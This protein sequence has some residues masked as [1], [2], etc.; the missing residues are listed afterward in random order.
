MNIK[1][2]EKGKFFTDIVTKE[3]VQAIIQTSTHLIY[4]QIHIRK[5]VRLKDELDLNQTFLA[6][7]N[8]EV[9]APDGQILY[10]TDFIAIQR[11]QIVWII[12]DENNPAEMSEAE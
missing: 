12:A 10:T 3:A 9:R 1:F 4:G 2:D 11:G 8:A 6:V 7:T 5:D